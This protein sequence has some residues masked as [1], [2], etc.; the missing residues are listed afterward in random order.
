[1]TAVID[2]RIVSS[3]AGPHGGERRDCTNGSAEPG[4]ERLLDHFVRNG[5]TCAAG[6]KPRFGVFG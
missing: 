1:M 3:I 4:I 2:L 5:E 6:A